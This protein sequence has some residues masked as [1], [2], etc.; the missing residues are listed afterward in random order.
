MK[1]NFVHPDFTLETGGNFSQKIAT[2]QLLSLLPP[3]ELSRP[4]QLLTQLRETADSVAELVSTRE[5][6]RTE[7]NHFS[8]QTQQYLADDDK[9]FDLLSQG[10]R[11]NDSCE[12][13]CHAIDLS[14]LDALLDLHTKLK[15]PLQDLNT[16]VKSSSF[17][18]VQEAFE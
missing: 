4:K 8:V 2:L 17:E 9:L 14:N 7:L 1:E 15:E 3:D 11:L 6:H 16:A 12:F 18:K 5:V 10:S 13:L